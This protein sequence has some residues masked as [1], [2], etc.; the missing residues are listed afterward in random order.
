MQVE[1]ENQAGC[2][3]G[4][5]RAV[6]LFVCTILDSETPRD[7]QYVYLAPGGD[8]KIF[9]DLMTSPCDHARRFKEMLHIAE[10]LPLG[11]KPPP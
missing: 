5:H 1:P 6:K 11:D 10:E 8:H 2:K 4:F 7:V 9:K 3:E